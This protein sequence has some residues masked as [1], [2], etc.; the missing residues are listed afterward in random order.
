MTNSKRRCS[1]CREWRVA[2]DMVG[3]GIERFCNDDCMLAKARQRS[4]S[5]RKAPEGPTP[6]TRQ[7]VLERDGHRC[8]WCGKPKP[9]HIHHIMYRSEGGPHTVDN[10]VT[11]CFLCHELVHSSKRVYQPLLH[12]VL[13]RGQGLGIHCKARQ[14]LEAGTVGVSGLSPPER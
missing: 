12:E 5:K 13:N 14:D 11:L 3:S 7:A 4:T 9:D 10:L 2:V 6:E 8:R 1:F